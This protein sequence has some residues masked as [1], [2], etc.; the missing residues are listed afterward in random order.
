MNREILHITQT[1]KKKKC[2]KDIVKLYKIESKNNLDICVI[3]FKKSF[4]FFF[5]VVW[6]L[7]IL[8]TVIINYSQSYFFFAFFF[9]VFLLSNVFYWFNKILHLYF[10]PRFWIQDLVSFTKW[11]PVMHWHCSLLH[12]AKLKLSWHKLCTWQR[13]PILAGPVT[14]MYNWISHWLSKH[15]PIFIV[16]YY[17]FFLNWSTNNIT[18]NH[19]L[20]M[21]L[22]ELLL[23]RKKSSLQVQVP[24]LHSAFVMP[25]HAEL[26]KQL[27]P[28]AMQ[29]K[30]KEAAIYHSKRNKRYHK[31]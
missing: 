13:S 21:Q 17:I 16:F 12:N 11:Y 7:L 29:K 30:H 18:G 25:W 5:F 31:K 20:L 23:S 2:S 10:L 8:L 6:I 27:N 24:C 26:S 9:S 1:A 4:R 15:K 28:T 14:F 22:E 19:S 3:S